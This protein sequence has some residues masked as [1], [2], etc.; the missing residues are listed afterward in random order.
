MGPVEKKMTPVTQNNVVSRISQVDMCA[1]VSTCGFLETF[2]AQ[3]INNWCLRAPIKH[4][5]THD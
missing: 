3:G 5:T 2:Y 1:C 4:A